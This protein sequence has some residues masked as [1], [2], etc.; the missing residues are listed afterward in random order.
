M[1]ICPENKVLNP[2]TNRCVSITGAIGKKIL[3]NVSKKNINVKIKE[4]NNFIEKNKN[5]IQYVNKIAS[6][7]N[8]DL[9]STIVNRLAIDKIIN[10]KLNENNLRRGSEKCLD[11]D[12]INYIDIEKILG[13]GS[14]GVVSLIKLKDSEIKIALKETKLHSVRKKILTDAF[15]VNEVNFLVN[16]INPLIENNVSPNFPYTYSYFICNTC[17]II[18][19]KTKLKNIKC[20][21]LLSE[22]ASG[23]LYNFDKKINNAE[24]INIDEILFNAYFQIMY[25]VSVLHKHTGIVHNDIKLENILYYKT[26]P[27]GFWRYIIGNESFYLPNLGYV[28]ILNDY[29]VSYHVFP[30]KSLKSYHLL[31][32]GN[33]VDNKFIQTIYS[34]F[35]TNNI[36]KSTLLQYKRYLKNNNIDINNV[37]SKNYISVCQSYDVMDSIYMFSG[38]KR[39]TQGDIRGVHNGMRLF[40]KSIQFK[41][42]IYQ[43]LEIRRKDDLFG[44]WKNLNHYVWQRIKYGQLRDYEN[45][46]YISGIH[47]LLYIYKNKYKIIPEVNHILET[48]TF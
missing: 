15:E 34:M 47:N 2:K 20:A 27:G 26:I 40:D 16:I 5:V 31:D 3:A 4:T 41:N 10:S 19:G 44:N 17:N 18:L 36:K 35:K 48:Y 11:K 13:Y 12:L 38:G 45:P 32:F 9:F 39:T 25:A 42:T 29:G 46:L 1:K 14:F 6:V 28:F 7:N 43:L 8:T 22:F 23:D 21:L 24:N 37:T 33:I 30:V